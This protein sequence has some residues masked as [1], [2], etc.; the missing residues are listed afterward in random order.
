MGCLA[1]M[2]AAE[3]VCCVVCTTFHRDG[4]PLEESVKDALTPGYSFEM[5]V[6]T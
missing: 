5:N 2:D 3:S 6:L 1:I 4:P